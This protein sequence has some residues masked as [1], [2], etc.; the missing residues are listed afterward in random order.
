[1][2]LHPF[3]VTHNK[4]IHY[5]KPRSKP[6]GLGEGRG[7]VVAT[8]KA[9]QIVFY[10]LVVRDCGHAAFTLGFATMCLFPAQHLLISL[11]PNAQPTIIRGLRFIFNYRYLITTSQPTVN[12][13]T[14]VRQASHVACTSAV[15][16][17]GAVAAAAEEATSRINANWRRGMQDDR[18][19]GGMCKGREADEFGRQLLR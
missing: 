7:D 13:S 9:L 5:R 16:A 4:A 6:D 18:V 1:M 17:R 11:L 15:T 12:R 3:L 10:V 2:L 8:A 19:A 14:R